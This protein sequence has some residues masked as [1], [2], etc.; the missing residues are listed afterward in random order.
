MTECHSVPSEG[1]NTHCDAEGGR[2][3]LT[4][5]GLRL[6][7]YVYMADPSVAMR[8]LPYLR[9]G[10]GGCLCFLPPKL[11]AKRVFRRMTECHSVPSKGRNHYCDAKGGRGLSS[12]ISIL[13]LFLS[14]NSSLTTFPICVMIASGNLNTSLF[15]YLNNRMPCCACKYLVRI[16]SCS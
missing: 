10:K 13:N 11:G 2:G 6:L 5:V 7:S 9:G 12:W 4:L 16:W 14:A 3:L 8:H 1:S 15:S